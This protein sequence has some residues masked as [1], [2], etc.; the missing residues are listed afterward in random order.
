VAGMLLA[1]L[2]KTQ[3]RALVVVSP[4]DAPA[5]KVA[6]AYL[7]S[8]PLGPAAAFSAECVTPKAELSWPVVMHKLPSAFDQRMPQTTELLD[9]NLRQTPPR[10]VE[11]KGAA[12]CSFARCHQLDFLPFKCDA[13]QGVFCQEH[14]PY[15]SHSCA[16]ADRGSVQVIIC[17]M[18]EASV[19]L[20][21]D[22]D[23]N[24][25]WERHFTQSCKQSLPSKTGPRRCPVA[26]CKEKLGPSNKFDCQQ[27]GQTVC[28][29]H[30]FEDEHDCRPAGRSAASSGLSGPGAGAAAAPGKK[31]KKSMGQRIG[32]VF[33][34]FKGDSSKKSLLG[35]SSSSRR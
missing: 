23:P 33:A 19:R 1:S 2:F 21:A 8:V 32:A 27:C 30:R 17:P 14:F 13:C 20:K 9:F 12:H 7:R 15:A 16:R 25:T 29:R 35:S 24:I 26:G 31:K 28:L 11:V 5:A 22:E 10:P 34:C 3:G 18:C 6:E 4:Q